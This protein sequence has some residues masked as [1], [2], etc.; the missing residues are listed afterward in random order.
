V[1]HADGTGV[2]IGELQIVEELITVSVLL[3]D[4]GG[5]TESLGEGVDFTVNL[6]V[7]DLVAR[8]VRAVRVDHNSSI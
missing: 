5:E 3:H 2:N 7:E 8:N 4:F 6:T 1:A